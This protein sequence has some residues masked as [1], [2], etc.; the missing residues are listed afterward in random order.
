MKRVVSVSLG[1]PKGDFSATTT[2]LGEE[3]EVSRVGTNGDLRRYAELMREFDGNVDAIGLGGID[4]YL[5]AGNRRYTIRDCAK[6]AANAKI[7]PVVD[8][9][10]LK[11]T[12][13]RE[14][15]DW[16]QRQGITDFSDKNVLV[17]CGVDRFGMAE[18]AVRLG[19][20]VVFGDLM[21]TVGIPI[22]I[23][24]YAGLKLVARTLLP[25]VCRLP[26]TW[27]YPTGKKQEQTTPKHERYFRWAD[28]IAG[29]NKIIGRFMPPPESG[30]LEGKLVITNTLTPAEIESLRAR[31]VK[32]LVTGTWELEGLG[33]RTPGTN[34]IE[35]ILIALSGK[36]PEEMTSA[37]YLDLLRRL[38]WKPTVREL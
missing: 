33:G 9:S 8:G 19:E 15:F 7:T 23:S 2:I 25:I 6:L 10:G 18:S 38:D 32:T 29:D 16:I 22:P 35:G 5:Y 24:S 36:R 1:S 37:D 4:L 30:A 28:V 34:V 3:F 20:A 31:G 11:N 17:V 12:L 27:I 14:T 21:F 13:E 26:F